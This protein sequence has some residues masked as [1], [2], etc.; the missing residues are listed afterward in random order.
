LLP[1]IQAVWQSGDLLLLLGEGA[2]GFNAAALAPFDAV[3]LLDSDIVAMHISSAEIPAAMIRATHALW[4][5]WTL[6]YSRSIT[7]R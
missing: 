2:A 3:A 6:D 1:E 5:T 4:A 7:W